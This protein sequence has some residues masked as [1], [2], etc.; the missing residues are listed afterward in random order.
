MNATR[1]IT[2][3][4]ATALLSSG[5]ASPLRAQKN[6]TDTTKVLVGPGNVNVSALAAVVDE[7]MKTVAALRS[8]VSGLEAEIGKIDRKPTEPVMGMKV[9]APFTVIDD[10]GK[11]IFT[12]ADDQYT[13]AY[14]G[15]VHFGPGSAG[16]YNM[17]FHDKNG[18]M[19]ATMGES[20][21]GTGLVAILR[22]G[23]EIGSMD[24]AGFIARTS[25][26]KEIA[27]LGADPS[28]KTRGR[29]VLRG[30]LSLTDAGGNTVVDAGAV[31]DGL[32]AVRAWPN[33][34]CRAGALAT[35]IKGSP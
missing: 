29:L 33:A 32:G 23:M 7:L 21:M 25:A 20:K 5:L 11:M 17:W 26:G 8:R 31:E 34:K 24:D 13:A 9:R 15:R 30:P 22:A 14:K 3:C 18:A 35:C 2:A 28:N 4:V 27:H 19:M 12:V 10:D 1:V 16:N 6:K